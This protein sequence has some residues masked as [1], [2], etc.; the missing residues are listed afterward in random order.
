MS[1]PRNK[2]TLLA[3]LWFAALW[4]FLLRES[5]GH[6]PPPFPHFDKA[7]HF[8]AF[9]AQFWLA[10]RAW[11]EARRRP[12]LLLLFAAAF[13]LAAASEAAQAAFTRTRSGDPADALADL[14]G[15]AAALFLADKVFRSRKQAV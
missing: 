12:P 1:L 10:A 13:L 6:A 15:T 8:A 4:Y 9:F 14:A 11:I 5:S 7:A 3:A 2:Y